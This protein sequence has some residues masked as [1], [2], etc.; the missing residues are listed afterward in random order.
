MDRQN[1]L[2]ILAPLLEEL[3]KI[4]GVRGVESDDNNSV[5]FNVFVTLNAINP[6]KF[7]RSIRNVKSDICKV[8][9]GKVK[10]SFLSQPVKRYE[11]NGRN[12][13]KFDKGYDSEHIKMEVFV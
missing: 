3:A 8:C 10:I 4:E 1:R 5:A 7:S 12:F 6:Y 2:L 11:S 9:K 13:P